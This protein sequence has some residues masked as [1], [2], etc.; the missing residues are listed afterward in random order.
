ME[1]GFHYTGQVSLDDLHDL[2][3]RTE[4]A[5]QEQGVNNHICSDLVIVVDEWITNIVN[6]GYAGN[7]G[8]VDLRVDVNNKQVRICIQDK[9]PEFNITTSAPVNNIDIHAPG[10]TPGGLGIE[11]IRRLVDNLEHS[12]SEDG[13]NKSC[14]IKNIS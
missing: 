9:G 5:L 13:W 7:N 12:R 1:P 4:H 2:R 6:H 14:F 11:L 10:S 3:Q 8:D